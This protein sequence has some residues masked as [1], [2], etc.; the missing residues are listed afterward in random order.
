MNAPGPCPHGRLDLVEDPCPRCIGDRLV[1]ILAREWPEESR[2]QLERIRKALVLTRA[3]LVAVEDS[4]RPRPVLVPDYELNRWV[5]GVTKKVTIGRCPCAECSPRFPIQLERG[6]RT[7]IPWEKIAPHEAQA[8]RNHDQSLK[9]LAERGGL[10]P[11]EAIWVLCDQ[12]IDWAAID[13]RKLTTEA[14]AL[15]ALAN[16]IGEPLP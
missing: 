13:S 2:G 15:V 8:Q 1:R 7:S 6:R 5:C 16:L 14:E 12:K 10:S 11:H 4:F 3:M 9:R